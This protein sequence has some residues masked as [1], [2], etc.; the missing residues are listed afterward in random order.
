MLPGQ[1]PNRMSVSPTGDRIGLSGAWYNSA[2]P[3]LYL[4]GD[5]GASFN[6]AGGTLPTGS[7]PTSLVV[8]DN[9]IYTALLSGH[10]IGGGVYSYSANVYA[11]IDNG[12][13]WSL[14]S[15]VDSV[16]PYLTQPSVSANGQRVV[17]G[18]SNGGL[19]V[20]NDGAS[21]WTTIS[22]SSIDPE[23]ASAGLSGLSYSIAIS[24]DGQRLNVSL[25]AY[26]NTGLF[27]EAALYTSTDAGA[28]WQKHEDR[29]AVS[30]TGSSST[31]LDGRTILAL[32]M[33]NY[34]GG[35]GIGTMTW[36]VTR[37]GGTT[38]EPLDTYSAYTGNFNLTLSGDGR[39]IFLS[40]NNGDAGAL[41]LIA[42]RWTPV[43]VIDDGEDDDA[44][45]PV[46][47]DPTL[48]APDTG[49]ASGGLSTTPALMGGIGILLITGLWLVARPGKAA[50][51][52]RRRV[53]ASARGEKRK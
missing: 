43:P 30:I 50:Q 12:T 14:R 2:S 21:T 10:D 35:T 48:G 17:L 32:D 51:P 19:L 15:S 9:V 46:I 4:S 24:E 38:W 33:S 36:V 23:L 41:R 11:S 18:S 34:D 25:Y 44:D 31:S 16:S 42:G 22:L 37:N 7:L 20:S 29:L 3:W 26:D 28:T 8:R 45:T 1:I 13:T 52:A 53:L 40:D 5:S 27:T 47:D 6:L 49:S 39:T